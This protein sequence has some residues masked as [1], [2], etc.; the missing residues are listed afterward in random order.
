MWSISQSGF[1]RN[2]VT[3]DIL[4]TVHM[5]TLPLFPYTRVSVPISRTS[6]HIVQLQR[7]ATAPHCRGKNGC[8]VDLQHAPRQ[9]PGGFLDRFGG[10]AQSRAAD[11]EEILGR[12]RQDERPH[13]FIES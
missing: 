9:V 3:E 12:K 11:E 10:H 7:L 8:R 6:Q 1:V 13:G 2:I 4:S 5:Y